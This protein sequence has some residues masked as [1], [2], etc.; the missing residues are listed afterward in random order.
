MPAKINKLY[1]SYVSIMLEKFNIA[2][3]CHAICLKLGT[4][5]F[6]S[7]LKLVLETSISFT[8]NE[9]LLLHCRKFSAFAIAVII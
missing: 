2:K 4:I 8:I 3:H 5:F 7:L 1:T 9:N 6:I